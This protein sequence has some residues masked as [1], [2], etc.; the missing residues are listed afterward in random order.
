MTMTDTA[1]TGPGE[2]GLAKIKGS[3]KSHLKA[4][5]AGRESA[6]DAPGDAIT[7]DASASDD[8][9]ETASF[10]ADSSAPKRVLG[11]K[12][13]RTVS[14]RAA[15]DD[16]G[17]VSPG[18]F[19]RLPLSEILSLGDSELADTALDVAYVQKVRQ[20]MM[21]RARETFGPMLDEPPFELWKAMIADFAEMKAD[22]L[23]MR[24]EIGGLPS[25][26]ARQILVDPL[27]FMGPTSDEEDA[28][29]PDRFDLDLRTDFVGSNWYGAEGGD[30]G[31]WRWSGPSTASTIVLPALGGG[32]LRIEVRF[33]TIIADPAYREGIRAYVN[34]DEYALTP[35]D[36]TTEFYFIDAEIAAT[37]AFD[38][39]VL[40]IEVPRTYSPAEAGGPNDPRK[41][42]IGL[43]G[44]A[45][46]RVQ[47]PDA[48]A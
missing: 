43:S 44:C 36:G 45:V 17:A 7:D 42:G 30:V 34:G 10:A 16:D 47:E 46:I 9:D 4:L 18:G 2:F 5:L 26:Q 1:D 11:R 32:K 21:D 31:G 48:A 41:L 14:L 38:R 27:S 37:Q 25:S 29:V 23:Y 13:P 8:L 24:G 12:R 39:M 22:L 33:N 40:R 28:P 20:D 19:T 35:V 15:P 3:K 6:A